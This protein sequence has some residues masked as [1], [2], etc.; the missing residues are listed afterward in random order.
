MSENELMEL[1]ES[2]E[3]NSSL[4]LPFSLCLSSELEDIRRSWTSMEAN[5]EGNA[6]ERGGVLG[7]NIGDISNEP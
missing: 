5:A 1:V 3:L 6:R 4:L 2:T 7:L